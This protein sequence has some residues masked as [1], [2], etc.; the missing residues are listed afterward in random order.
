MLIVEQDFK[1][2]LSIAVI[3]VLDKKLM[4]MRDEAKQLSY[5][6]TGVV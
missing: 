1:F 4:L 3:K 6:V 2:D 5:D